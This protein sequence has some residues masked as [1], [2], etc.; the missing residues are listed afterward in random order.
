MEVSFLPVELSSVEALQCSLRQ[1]DE[2]MPRVN[3]IVCLHHGRNS[4]VVKGK[5]ASRM[6]GIVK[7]ERT[8]V[9]LIQEDWKPYKNPFRVH[10]FLRSG[11]LQ[12]FYAAASSLTRGD[13]VYYARKLLGMP[14]GGTVSLD[15]VLES[16]SHF[17]KGLRV[18]EEIKRRKDYVKNL[19]SRTR[20]MRADE[21]PDLLSS[22]DSRPMLIALHG[23]SGGSHE[24]Y[25]RAVLDHVMKSA[26]SWV[27]CALNSRG[28]G[29]TV[30]TN[31]K[32]FCANWTS[33]SF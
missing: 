27:C 25:L 3:N 29:R 20:Y 15:L 16:E 33:L 11:H 5:Q 4:V 2:S 23:L 24:S 7:P 13:Q 8:L 31:Q 6:N 1:I 12:T 22:D 28:C 10:P 9:D 21:E 19:P 30:I 26:Q 17:K 32:F 14:D 18:D